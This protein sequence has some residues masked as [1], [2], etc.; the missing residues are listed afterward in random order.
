M[1]GRMWAPH[2]S[3]WGMP[4]GWVTSSLSGIEWTCLSHSS[5]HLIWKRFPWISI[6]PF[7]NAQP[8]SPL[9]IKFYLNWGELLSNLE[10]SSSMFWVTSIQSTSFRA[11]CSYSS[12]IAWC[13]SLGDLL[14]I[15]SIKSQVHCHFT[16]GCLMK[17]SQVAKSSGFAQCSS[18]FLV[19]SPLFP[20]KVGIPL[21]ALIP[22]P[23]MIIIFFLLAINSPAS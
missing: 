18:Y 16:S 21:A 1:L 20:L 23:V 17:N 14:Q 7:V 4:S 6:T 19:Q 22:A 3:H 10:C 12:S 11:Q 13:P 2:F 5:K 9:G 8:C 15:I